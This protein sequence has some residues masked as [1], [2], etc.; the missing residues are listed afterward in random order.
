MA[1]LKVRHYWIKLRLY[2][3]KQKESFT[4]WSRFKLILNYVYKYTYLF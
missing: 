4:D 1:D 2:A 3:T